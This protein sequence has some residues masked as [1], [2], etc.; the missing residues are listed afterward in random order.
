MTGNEETSILEER[1]SAAPGA[2][3]RLANP[4]P[5][6]ASLTTARSYMLLS[7]AAAVITITLKVAAYLLTDS[8]GLLS[9]AAESVIN[10]VAALAGF[11][12]LTVAAR[13][14]DEEHVYGHTKA[15]YF[16]SGL[17]GSLILV[18]AG[19]IAVTAAGRLLHPQPLENLGLGLIVSLIATAVNGAVGLILIRAGRRLQSITLRAD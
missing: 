12:A 10:L 19:A 14:P 2:P 3:D 11:V 1:G 6:A 15:E 5:P 16:S 7:I 13:P 9:D 18:A 4:S 17:E 8:V